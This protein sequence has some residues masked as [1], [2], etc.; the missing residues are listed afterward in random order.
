MRQNNKWKD[1]LLSSS[2]PLE[3]ETASILTKEGFF[4]DFDFAYKR[5]DEKEEKE[6]SIDLLAKRFGGFEQFEIEAFQID[7]VVE[8]KYRNPD[9]KWVFLSNSGLDNEIIYFS[10]ALKLI[11]HFSEVGLKS[12]EEMFQINNSDVLPIS[13]ISKKGIEI[14]TANGEVHDTGIHHGI[15][16]L[17]YSLPIILS[18]VIKNSFENDLSMV[19]PYAYCPILVTT[20]DLRILNDDFSIELVKSAETLEEISNEIPYL[21]FN[22]GLYPSFKIHCKNVFQDMPD[23]TELERFNYFNDLHAIEVKNSDSK[24]FPTERFMNRL[25]KGLERSCFNDFIICNLKYLPDLLNLIKNSINNVI[26]DTEKLTK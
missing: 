17:M 25:K 19:F 15:N 18:D 26:A 5:L 11:P 9:V 4:V 8:C 20:A 12:N 22:T 13:T 23:K 10:S 6:F 24:I 1:R 16:Q 21:I 3:Y 14:N 2:I 7:L